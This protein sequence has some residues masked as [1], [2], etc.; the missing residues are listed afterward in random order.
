MPRAKSDLVNFRA[1]IRE[2]VRAD[3]EKAA[4]EHGISMSA[5][6][7]RRL[8]E[9]FRRERR[10]DEIIGR[11]LARLQESY[12]SPETMVALTLMGDAI[13]VIEAGRKTKWF[14]DDGTRATVKAACSTILDWF[15]PGHDMP[16][17]PLA[18]A[19]YGRE[20]RGHG[21][22]VASLALLNLIMDPEAQ[23]TIKDITDMVEPRPTFADAVFG[24]TPQDVALADA[25]SGILSEPGRVERMGHNARRRI[26]RVFRWSDAAAGLVNVFEETLRA[27]HRRPRAA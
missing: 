1:R 27:T 18:I 11:E 4:K 12:S 25:I 8:E 22:K 16:T 20:Y 26:Q 14:E 23:R 24:A 10:T 9:S 21:R 7:S 3:I 19:A 5:E 15:V 13:K 6:A 17:V 2:P